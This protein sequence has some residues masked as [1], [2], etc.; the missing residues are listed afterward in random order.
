M[1]YALPP[2]G[3]VSASWV[4]ET[5]YALPG[6]G[7]ADATWVSGPVV[8][9]AGATSL[10]VITNIGAPRRVTFTD[11]THTPP[12]WLAGTPISTQQSPAVSLGIITNLGT[13]SHPQLQTEDATGFTST[14]VGRPI[15]APYAPPATIH[16]GAAASGALMTIFGTAT[17][18]SPVVSPTTGSVVTLFGTP[19]HVFGQQAAAIEPATLFGSATALVTGRVVGSRP[20]LFGTPVSVR[21]QPA[22]ST[23]RATRWGTPDTERSDTYIARGLNNSVR[24]AQPTALRLNAFA[25]SGATSTQFGTPACHQRYRALHT[26]STCRFGKPLMLWGTPC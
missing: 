17:V 24:F 21:V 9:P 20:T 12:T 5:A 14:G 4:G 8:P 2:A 18:D 11:A 6:V 1:S 7:T 3:T 10:G 23:Y 16:R 26:A 13:P 19:T 22:T 15:T 25:A